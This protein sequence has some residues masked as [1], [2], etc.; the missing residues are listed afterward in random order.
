M[1]MTIF[2]DASHDA[3][4]DAL[5]VWAIT[6]THWRLLA[7]EWKA[8]LETIAMPNGEPCPAFHASAMMNQKGSFKGWGR[9]EA[10]NA[11]GN[12]TPVIERNSNFSM[13]PMGVAVEIPA[14]FA[15]VQRDSVWLI[16][17]SKFFQMI[18]E[19]YPGAQSGRV[20]VRQQARDCRP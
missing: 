8:M 20:R 6:P 15:A 14:D 1:V 5:G 3:H 16:L 19:T 9:I 4:T 10:E 13:S 7:E 2:S 11:F 17:F 12:A 18:L